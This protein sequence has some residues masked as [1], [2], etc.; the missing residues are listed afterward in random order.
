VQRLAVLRRMNLGLRRTTGVVIRGGRH[1][2]Y[3]LA[4]PPGVGA[5]QAVAVISQPIRDPRHGAAGHARTALQTLIRTPYRS[6][7]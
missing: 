5:M 6:V 2:P 3:R 7:T 4:R 1:A